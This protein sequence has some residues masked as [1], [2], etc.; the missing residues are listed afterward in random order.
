MALIT[1]AYFDEGD[2]SKVKLLLDTYHH[3]NSCLSDVDVSQLSP[4]LYVGLSARD[5]I[6]QFRHKALLLFK[7]LLLE[8]R[9]VFYRSPVHPLCVTILSLLS[10]HPGMIDHGLEESACVKPSRPMSP[11]PNFADVPDKVIP[12][13]TI[14]LDTQKQDAEKWEKLS[15]HSPTSE[16]PIKTPLYENCNKLDKEISNEASVK[17]PTETENEISISQQL[18][19]TAVE[20]RWIEVS[21]QCAP[22]LHGSDSISS[23]SV[24][25]MRGNNTSSTLNRDISVDTLCDT[26][27]AQSNMATIALV[28]AEQCGVPLMLFTQGYLC[29]PYLSLPYLDL[30]SDVN[31]R[32]YVVGATNVLF[33]QKKQLADVLIEVEGARVETQDPELRRQLHL[34]TEDLRFADFIVRHVSEDRHDV[35]LNGVGWEGGEEW[36]RSQFRVY[37]LCLMRTSLLQDESREAEH[38]NAHFMSA[39]KSTHNYKTWVTGEHAGIWDL[40]PGHPFAGQLSVADMKLRLSHTMQ[41]TEGGRKLNQAMTSTGRAVATTGRAVGGALSQAKGALSSWWS[42]LTT[43]QSPDCETPVAA[44]NSSGIT[45]SSKVLKEEEQEDKS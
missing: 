29:H 42:T 43:P 31:V 9:L 10:L 32:G 34:T 2:F 36:I 17:I 4:Q 45:V 35:F 19:V 37:L 11:I 28:P 3:L 7:L 21:A 12:S 5:F 8:R 38:F 41:N 33:K 44:E 22:N 30:L 15:P 26:S 23:L 25:A 1:H 13:A 20:E 6:L 40:N 39:W 18:P 14:A 27:V 16:V 24:P